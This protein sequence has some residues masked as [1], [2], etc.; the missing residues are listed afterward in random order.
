VRIIVFIIGR[1]R[2]LVFVFLL[3]E[4]RITNTCNLC[5]SRKYLEKI[6]QIIKRL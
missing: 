1:R 3:C 6:F 5:I 2:A 4:N